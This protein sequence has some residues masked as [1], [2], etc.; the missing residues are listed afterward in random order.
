[1]SSVISKKDLFNAYCV[2]FGP[3]DEITVDLLKNLQPLVVRAAYRK[4]ALETHPDRS[5]ALGKAEVEMNERFI[6]VATA[7]ENLNS[8]MKGDRIYY[9]RGGIGIRKKSKEKTEETSKHRDFSDHLYKGHLPKHKL[10]I[11][12]FLYYSGIISWR[13]LIS[14]ITWQKR[15]RPPIGQIALK[16]GILSSYEVKKILTGRRIEQSYREKFCQYACRKGYI[17]SIERTTLLGEQRSLE[18]P[19][20]EFFTEQGI[21]STEEMDRMV[22]RLQIHNRC[23]F[24]TKFVIRDY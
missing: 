12:Q 10:L 24:E 4:K 13:T 3:E 17:T 15:Q 14:A 16:S 6:E 22:G 9:F 19:L 23:A 11:G 20:G 21:L 2:L 18:R 1:M 7:Y 5:R 8:L